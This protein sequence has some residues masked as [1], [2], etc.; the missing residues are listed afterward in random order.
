MEAFLS[1]NREDKDIARRLGAQ[2][3]LAG[4]DI[5]FDEW[6]IRAGESIPGKVNEALDRIDSV[7]VL[8]SSSANDSNWVRAELETAIHDGISDGNLRVIPV[9]LDDTVLP[10]LLRPA[11]RVDLR[12]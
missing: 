7:I 6:E 9:L 10:A 2:L 11:K 3:K 5:W 4:A 8:W 1:H 12:D